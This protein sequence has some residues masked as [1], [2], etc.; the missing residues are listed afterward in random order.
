MK[1]P[2]FRIGKRRTKLHPNLFGDDC[3]KEECAWWVGELNDCAI[4]RTASI[5]SIAGSHII[6][7]ETEL[8]RR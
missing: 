7:I 4:P 5:L 2:L 6:N 3:L 8:K 1:C